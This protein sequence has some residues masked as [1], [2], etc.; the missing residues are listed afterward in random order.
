MALSNHGSRRGRAA[1]AGWTGAT[2]SGIRPKYRQRRPGRRP[3]LRRMC[4]GPQD[5]PRRQR[6]A[7]YAVIVRDGAVL[8][9]RLAPSV[10]EIEMWTL[11]GGGIDFGEHPD[12]AVVREVHEE[13]GLDVRARQADLDRLGPPGRRPR[14]RARRDALGAD[15]LRRLGGR[16]RARASRRRGGRLH[17]GRPVGVRSSTW[18]RELCRRCR[19]CAR[20]WSIT[21]RR[22][23]SGSPPTRWSAV[24]ARCCSPATLPSARTRGSGPCPGGG[25]DHGETPAA[26]VSREVAEETGLV[27]RVG[28]LLG[29]HDEHFTGTAPHGRVEDFHGVHLVF[30][31]TVGG[32][33]PRVRDAGGT[34]DA[35]RWFMP[36]RSSPPAPSKA[37][38]RCPDSSPPRWGC[39]PA[40]RFAS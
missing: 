21:D 10:S 16:R 6:V 38:S 33:G 31:A 11:P 28:E 3:R 9:S 40:S 17:D 30:A 7:A 36:P 22:A 18:T 8:L 35:V 20:P 24:T 2:A 14:V 37:P 27:A 15:R 13:T 4:P 19:W 23:S 5:L 26:A 25:L 29:V 32:G 12:D 39:G 34:T 1:T